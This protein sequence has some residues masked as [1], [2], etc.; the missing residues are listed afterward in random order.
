[1]AEISRLRKSPLR[2]VVNHVEHKSRDLVDH[3]RT[4]TVPIVGELHKLTRPKRKHSSYPTIRSVCIMQERL[5]RSHERSLQLTHEIEEC[6]AA[7]EDRLAQP[8]S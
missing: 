6:V 8:D 1:M 3:L 2:D 5:R 4:D 7:I